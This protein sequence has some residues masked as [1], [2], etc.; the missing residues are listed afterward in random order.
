MYHNTYDKHVAVYFN[1]VT[2]CQYFVTISVMCP[3]FEEWWL[4]MYKWVLNFQNLWSLISI[5][6]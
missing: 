3:G 5:L 4:Y 2:S 1:N 6:R